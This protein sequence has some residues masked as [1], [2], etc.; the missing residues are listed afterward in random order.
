M[1][2]LERRLQVLFSEAQ[3]QALAAYAHKLRKPIGAV[4]RE[5]VQDTL[6]HPRRDSRA[7]LE[8]LFASWDAAP[9]ESMGDWD[10]V[11][12]S[13]ERPFLDGIS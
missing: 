4:V 12:A 8:S 5:S 13:F 6:R 3:Y 11:K 2:V 9:G 1:A 7:A 10:D